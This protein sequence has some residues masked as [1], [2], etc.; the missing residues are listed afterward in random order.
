MPPADPALAAPAELGPVVFTEDQIRHRVA[1]M[2]ADLSTDYVDKKPVIIGVLAGTVMFMADLLRALTV[3]VEVDFLAISRFGPPEE[4]HGAVRVLKDLEIPLAGRHAVV[5][6]V[7]VDTGFTLSHILGT[8]RA[9][10]PVSVRVC[11][12][13]NRRQR[14][15]INVPLDYVGFDAPD[16]FLVGYGMHYRQQ[17]RQLPYIA[18]CRV[19]NTLS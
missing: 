5:V 15:L 2:A 19:D 8:L 10:G 18:S 1:E 17:Y 9:R 14:R 7:L 13:L 11:A 12:L 3:P 6:E 4:T 16:D